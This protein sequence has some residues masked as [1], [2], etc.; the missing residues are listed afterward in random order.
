MLNR[1]YIAIGEEANRGTKEVS[2]VGFIPVESAVVPAFAAEDSKVQQFRGED[3]VKGETLMRR[4]GKSWG[5]SPVIPF[6]SES[7]GAKGLMLAILHHHFGYGSTANVGASTAY[8]HIFSPADEMFSA[9]NLGSKALTV[10]TNLSEGSTMKNWPY[11][12]GRI[13]TL[14]LTQEMTGQLTITPEFLGQ[15][16][17]AVTAEIGSP[18]FA[19]E[20]LRFDIHNLKVYTG[21]IS[22][23]GTAPDY[24]DFDIASAIHIKPDVVSFTSDN[25]MTDNKRASGLEYAD[26]SRMGRFIGSMELSFDWDTTEFNTVD[27]YNAYVAGIAE[28]EFI[29]VWDTGVE[30]A[31]GANHKFIIHIPRAVLIGE[32]PEYQLDVDAMI[33][34]KYEILHDSTTHKYPYCM[35]LQNSAT[36]F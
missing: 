26:K 19:A 18:V 8:Q 15:F 23:T 32:P 1:I 33:S 12:G 4:Y 22:P 6:Y 5:A 10:N 24:T 3:S 35:Y 11:V 20:N 9:G 17:D 13:K 34:L 28:R 31:S 27:E 14:T 25:G 36:S 21:T 29:L 30:A 7:G 16:R 2:T